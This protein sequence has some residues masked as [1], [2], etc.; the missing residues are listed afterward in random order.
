MEI[1]SVCSLPRSTVLPLASL[2]PVPFWTLSKNHLK[3]DFPGGPVV[4]NLPCRAEQG[5]W[6]PWSGNQDPTCRGATEPSG[7]LPDATKIPRAASKTQRRQINEN[8]KY[9]SKN[10]LKMS[11]HSLPLSSSLIFFCW[12]PHL[13]LSPTPSGPCLWDK[14]Q[15]SFFS[16]EPIPTPSSLWRLGPS[17]SLQRPRASLLPSGSRRQLMWTEPATFSFHPHR[18]LPGW[19]RNSTWMSCQQHTQE[20]SERTILAPK[21]PLGSQVPQLLPEPQCLAD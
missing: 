10:H 6:F 11:P 7:S 15:S 16:A 2:S 21:I 14:K 12:L 19:G 13:T 17:V 8:K 3:R 9:V 18:S 20:A 1:L 4:K 5:M